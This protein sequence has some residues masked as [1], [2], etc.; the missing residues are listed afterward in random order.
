MFGRD[1]IVLNGSWC[2][3]LSQ[4]CSVPPVNITFCLSELPLLFFCEVGD[5]VKAE[6][7]FACLKLTLNVPCPQGLRKRCLA[8]AQMWSFVMRGTASRTAMPAPRRP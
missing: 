7:H 3:F 1:H 4:P 8:P 6:L 5:G 2:Y